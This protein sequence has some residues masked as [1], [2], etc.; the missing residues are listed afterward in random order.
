VDVSTHNVVRCEVVRG[1]GY[2]LTIEEVN[3]LWSQTVKTVDTVRRMP[4]RG[5]TWITE[6]P[7]GQWTSAFN[8]IPTGHDWY[9]KDLRN[10]LS[11]RVSHEVHCMFQCSLNK[12]Y[13]IFGQV[14]FNKKCPR[15]VFDALCTALAF[16][17]DQFCLTG[18][19]VK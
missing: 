18:V 11:I 13:G 15:K 4:P 3:H 19:G 10:L 6:N 17:G 16:D 1:N 9:H 5:I 8:P 2:E 7:G 12:Q 14:R